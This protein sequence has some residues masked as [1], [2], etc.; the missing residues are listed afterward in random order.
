MQA[1]K[2]IYYLSQL[3]NDKISDLPIN[4]IDKE[5]LKK[6]GIK[7]KFTNP[8]MYVIAGRTKDY[9]SEQMSDL[10]I[11]KRKYKNVIDIISYDD[12]LNRL[13]KLINNFKSIS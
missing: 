6:L 12:I 1:E 2:Y 8:K 3:G 11:I 9:N 7:I 13:D 4:K 5:K 10:E